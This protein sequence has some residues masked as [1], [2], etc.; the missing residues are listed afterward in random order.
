MVSLEKM[1]FALLTLRERENR[2]DGEGITV[3]MRK[4]TS[5]EHFFKKNVSFR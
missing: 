1:F 3:S 5:Q 2:E 4:K